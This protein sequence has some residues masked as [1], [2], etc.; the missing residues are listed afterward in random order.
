MP[1]LP[2]APRMAPPPG[3]YGVVPPPPMPPEV[4][5]QYNY[6][7]PPGHAY[8]GAG[9][10]TRPSVSSSATTSMVLGIC[11]I[12]FSVLCWPVG[13]VCAIVGLVMSLSTRKKISSGMYSTQGEG[14]A[15]AGL[16][17]SVI[18]LCLA[19]LVLVAWGAV[20]ASGPG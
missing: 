3:S 15:K 7:Y 18:A 12:V 20:L 10:D 17:M 9:Y 16:V 11:A 6:G 2:P 14:Q 19:V 13:V 5:G 4:G 1:P 8:P